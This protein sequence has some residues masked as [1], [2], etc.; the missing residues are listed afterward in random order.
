MKKIILLILNLSM[1]VGCKDVP[2]EF[3]EK[4][5]DF[6]TLEEYI[7]EFG[8][9]DEKIDLVEEWM[10]KEVQREDMYNPKKSIEEIIKINEK[11]ILYS[12][13]TRWGKIK[14]RSIWSK[15]SMGLWES[16]RSRYKEKNR[17]R[18]NRQLEFEKKGIDIDLIGKHKTE[19]TNIDYPEFKYKY[20]WDLGESTY[21]KHFEDS[22]LPSD[23]K[24]QWFGFVKIY[25]ND[26][27]GSTYRGKDTY[28]TYSR[29]TLCQCLTDSKYS[30]SKL[31]KEKFWERYKT[32]DPSSEQMEEDYYNCKN[33]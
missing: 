24:I 10:K 2:R 14:E 18:F 33:K 5:Y 25:H 28:F 21:G 13:K 20:I 11:S 9:P 17:D 15:K 4:S 19:K 30:N 7:N 26:S 6:K 3:I 27:T 12:E 8:E 23:T 32:D 22:D 1:M 29:V 31:C 16:E